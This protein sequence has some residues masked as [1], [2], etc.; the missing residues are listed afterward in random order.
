MGTLRGSY[1]KGKEGVLRSLD[2][3]NDFSLKTKRVFGSPLLLL[4]GEQAGAGPGQGQASHFADLQ[5]R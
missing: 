4:P 5:M 2:G 1:V 3:T